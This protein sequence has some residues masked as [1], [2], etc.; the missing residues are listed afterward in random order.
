MST[1]PQPQVPGEPTKTGTAMLETATAAVQ[2]F[3]PINKIHQ[4]LCAYLLLFTLLTFLLFLCFL[5]A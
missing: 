1:H 5:V 4:H 3:G 2:K